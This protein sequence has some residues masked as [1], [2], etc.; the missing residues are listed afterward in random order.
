M[1]NVMAKWKTK[2]MLKWYI[3]AVDKHQNTIVL[4]KFYNSKLKCVSPCV[5]ER[6]RERTV[7]VCVFFIILRSKKKLIFKSTLM[8]YGY[9]DEW[10]NI[11]RQLVF[12]N[13]S[14]PA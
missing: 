10:L 3:L 7:F 5:R 6:E 14:S 8:G 9:P 13:R 1:E 12:S 11:K 2:L 4:I